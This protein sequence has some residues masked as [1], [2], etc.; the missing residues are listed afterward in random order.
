MVTKLVQGYLLQLP[1]PQGICFEQNIKYAL[2]KSRYIGSSVVK[3][4]RKVLDQY[5]I[6]GQTT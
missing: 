6:D 5:I 2:R 4:Q 3:N 1:Q